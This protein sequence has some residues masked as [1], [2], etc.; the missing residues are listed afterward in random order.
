MAT[1]SAV[2]ST[3]ASRKPSKPPCSS[4]ATNSR[5][6]PEHR[7]EQQRH[8]EHAGGEVAVERRA[9]QPEVEEHERRDREERHRGDRLERAQLDPQVLAQHRARPRASPVQR[10]D[11]RRRRRRRRRASSAGRPPRSPSARSASAS[12]PRGSWLVTT[13]VRPDARPMSGSTSSIEP[14]VEV[15]A[16]LVEQQ[17]RRVVQHRAADRRRAATSPRLSVC[18]GS[19]ARSAQP[20]RARAARRCARV[21]T[22]CSRAWK[23]RFSRARQLA[24]EQRVVA[25]Q[26]DLPAH[27]PAPRRGSSWPSTRAVP[28]C[29]RSSVARIRSSVDLPAPLGPK[30]TSVVPGR[31]ASA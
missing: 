6:M 10:P 4:S 30:T 13:R 29:G 28:A 7:G 24:V 26:A 19:S 16:R 15:R 20:R 9:V 1:N 3:G 22:P 27:R 12:P 11:R 25:E 2:R 17:Q 18:T 8:P 31:D 21:A 5:F 14:R 23:R